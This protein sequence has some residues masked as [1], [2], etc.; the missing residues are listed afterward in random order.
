MKAIRRNAA[1]VL[2]ERT[3]PRPD[4]WIE[5]GRDAD[6]RGVYGVYDRVKDAFWQAFESGQFPGLR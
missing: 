6:A 4:A 3:I 1:R 5:I 2:A